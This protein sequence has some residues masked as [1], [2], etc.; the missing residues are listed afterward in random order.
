MVRQCVLLSE[1]ISEL[2]V[3]LMAQKEL[4]TTVLPVC[5][6]SRGTYS[7]CA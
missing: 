3:V 7:P 6:F 2:L 5:I 1:C 4:A